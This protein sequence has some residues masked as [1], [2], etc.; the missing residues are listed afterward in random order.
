MENK[1]N[2]QYQF[3]TLT[4]VKDPVSRLLLKP[5]LKPLL[6]SATG[7]P[8]TTHRAGVFLRF[9][10]CLLL[11]V[12][13]AEVSGQDKLF[14]SAL[15][16]GKNTIFSINADGTNKIQL[17]N[18]V[19]NR[20]YPVISKDGI[21]MLYI[22]YKGSAG[23]SAWICRATVQG[24]NEQ[25]LKLIPDVGV[26]TTS[27]NI[28]AGLSWSNDKNKVLYSIY[29]DGF[30]SA[31]R[32]GD[33]Y[34]LNLSTNIVTNLTNE[35]DY[36]K[37][38]GLQYSPDNSKIIFQR[39][40]TTY[41]AF[42]WAIYVM[43][44]DGSGRV[45]LNFGTNSSYIFA[46]TAYSNSGSKV[47]YQG[48]N[49]LSDPI[50]LYIA[51]SD[52]TGAAQVIPS[53]GATT[54]IQNACFSPDDSKIA[55]MRNDSLI[56][57]QINGTV[58]SRFPKGTHNTFN[59]ITWANI[60][61]IPNPPSLLTATP[62]SAT[63][64]GLAWTD[65]STNETAFK[66]QRS[67]TSGTGFTTIATLAA[68][69]ITY[70]DNTVAAGTTY[71]YRILATNGA[72]DSAPSNEANATTFVIEK[73]FFAAIPTSE[74]NYTIY[75]SNV[76]GTGIQRIFNDGFNRNNYDVSNDGT[77]L[78]YIKSGGGLP[79]QQLCKSDIYGCN[80]QILWTNTDPI[81]LVYSLDWSNNKQK[82]VMELGEVVN[83]NSDLY[84]FNLLTS[85]LSQ[86]TNSYDFFKGLSTRSVRYSPDDSKILYQYCPT[87]FFALPVDM[88]V[89][90]ADGSNQIQLTNNG[91]QSVNSVYTPD[92]QKIIYSTNSF[93][94]LP[95]RIMNADG[96]NDQP[97]N[98]SSGANYGYNLAISPDGLKI[99]MDR[100][101]GIGDGN[102]VVTQINGTVLYEVPKVGFNGY[103]QISWV[104]TYYTLAPSALVATL[105]SSSQI[106]LTWTDNS[107]NED[108][109]VVE[110]SLTSGSG[111][112]ALA[113]LPANT[114]AYS[115]N[116]VSEGVSYFYRVT[117]LKA[118]YQ[119]PYSNEAT[120]TTPFNAPTVSAIAAPT[121]LAASLTFADNSTIE[122]NV[123][124]ER[125][126]TTGT[127]F[128]VLATL[129]ANTTTY[130]DNT[131]TEGITYFY[132]LRN[133]KT[134]STYSAY[135][136]EASV[137]VPAFA[138]PTA[139][140]AAAVNITQINLSWADNTTFETAYLLER[141]I[142]P[143]GGGFA[144]I[145]TLPA[146]STFYADNTVLPA[147]QYYYRVRGELTPIFS[148]Y[149]GVAGATTA[150]I[151]PLAQATNITLTAIFSQSLGI[152]WTNGGGTNRIVKINTSNNFTNLVNA[153]AYTAN[154]NYG[155]I[156]EQV[157]YNGGGN[158]AF[159]G[160]LQPKTKYFFKVYEYNG[161]GVTASYLNTSAQGNPA[162]FLTFATPSAPPTDLVF[163]D[164]T[165]T[166]ISGRF[167]PT[168]ADGYL[169]VRRA[170]G[171]TPQVPP[172][173]LTLKIGDI[174]FGEQ[175]VVGAGKLTT[176]K[177]EKL[178]PATDYTFDVYA[179]N[180]ENET[181]AYSAKPLSGTA[182]THNPL[183]ILEAIAPTEALAGQGLVTLSAFGKDFINGATVLWEGISLPAVFVSENELKAE[184]GGTYFLT[185]RKYNISVS[186][187]PLGGGKSKELPFDVKPSYL[188]ESVKVGDKFVLPETQNHLLHRICIYAFGENNALKQIKFD[189]SGTFKPQ[190][191][192]KN[193]FTLWA[194]K[195][196]LLDD[197]DVK[198]KDFPAASRLVFETTANTPL[199][200]K[201]GEP[202]CLLLTANIAEKATAGHTIQVS[203]ITE[204]DISLSK[205]VALLSGTIPYQI[206]GIQTI[207]RIYLN[208]PTDSLLLV[209]WC[210]VMK[211]EE[212]E[213]KWDFSQPVG[214]WHGI[215]LD[216]N[217][218]V[219]GI[220]LINNNLQGDLSDEI[221][222]DKENAITS[223]MRYFNCSG[224]KITGEMPEKIS[225]C[226]KME[227][228]DVSKNLM[229]GKLTEGIGEVR[230]LVTLWLSYNRFEE[231]P[232]SIENCQK[233]RN[234][235]CNNNKIS[236]LPENIGKLT[237]LEVA[238]FEVNEL[239]KLPSTFASLPNLK[240]C[241]LQNNALHFEHL[242]PLADRPS[243][244][245]T[246]VYAPQAKIGETKEIYAEEGKTFEIQIDTKGKSNQYTWHK[247]EKPYQTTKEPA[248]KEV[249]NYSKTGTYK[250]M[251]K[252]EKC[253]DL[254]L[255]SY[256]YKVKMY[257]NNNLVQ[258]KAVVENNDVF[259]ADES[260]EAV[261]RA[262]L[263]ANVENKEKAT[264][265]W[266]KNSTPIFQAENQKFVAQEVG[267]YSVRVLLPNGCTYLSETVSISKAEKVA[268]RLQ[269]EG[270]ILK[271]ITSQE[272]TNYEWFLNN[273]LLERNIT[274]SL[275][276]VESGRYKVRLTDKN[277]CQTTSAEENINVTALEEIEIE[278]LSIELFPNPSSDIFR[279]KMSKAILKSIWVFDAL[280]RDAHKESFT[281]PIQEYAFSLENKA[282]G[283][284][285][286][287]IQTTEGEAQIR[288]VKE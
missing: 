126:L 252:N 235:H 154:S 281:S 111:F 22:K 63:S 194:S 233:L 161:T 123:I 187:P 193:A 11:M 131:V 259:C 3:Q 14:Y 110:R 169:I 269:R 175:V 282:V 180:G 52:G 195:D 18:D 224:N 73:L 36:L 6:G 168:V 228:L 184:I 139:L 59:Q 234:L 105:I 200:I 30:P 51:N 262:Q 50:K 207:Q 27:G 283:I 203:P 209:R 124:L 107:S 248:Y 242:E 216:Q 208:N 72:G 174:L 54:G 115:D 250:L 238:R 189:L 256:E 133:L 89:M 137:G 279:V 237:S 231:I 77:E 45:K 15:I 55:F 205:E 9:A 275:N 32:D 132:R 183:P 225:K 41:F 147:T 186:N 44:A 196:T 38:N 8:P 99:A 162:S 155:G 267:N 39:L 249:V 202:L 215:D 185:A 150:D 117:A 156:G 239:K 287:R 116:T 230:N 270:N 245:K 214:K 83:R 190:D 79:Q 37:Q 119:S 92:S 221:F 57:A 274:S 219:R 171:S 198:L 67:L 125:S 170:K 135:S 84:V 263:P 199:P 96:T 121:P 108:S 61:T 153:T 71:Y 272:I 268:V 25:Q 94:R 159:V 26:N 148:A 33:I 98:L 273:K 12:G 144:L 191:L 78:I 142:L 81:N 182:R 87:G 75:V 130:T 201:V 204:K 13:A 69:T 120:A 10:L 241:Y 90:N 149:S 80:E 167:K 164:I 65:N 286:V 229:R 122:D 276:M 212:W 106:N 141:S 236:K 102:L 143:T 47:I 101:V 20:V 2:P 104:N 288:I 134:P 278:N 66:V 244:L 165:T 85:T 246:F 118:C 188:V 253:K 17:F 31:N 109:Y 206:G 166:T 173:G 158:T 258:I 29:Y 243:K 42:P 88:Y 64:I 28:F 86:L 113:T 34:E 266:L 48:Y 254:T 19:Y 43:N 146:G 160:G 136:A 138:A 49:S 210:R 257:C 24:L 60:V 218:K 197:K 226:K 163:T 211:G 247:D 271:A 127:G 179:Y 93:S 220:I 151:T 265:Q 23:D 157:V 181:I 140:F 128:T 35:W 103:S 82:V 176:F 222:T 7:S 46:S 74:T 232:E 68:N 260:I 40:E 172:N 1:L 251:V 177:A 217:G 192:E 100:G 255:E 76:D 114:V 227:Y 280:G 223:E 62:T 145:A 261:L 277:G 112:A 178:T 58:L 95:I 70:T 91:V 240:E 21:E 264:F 97:L 5:R 285:W 152:S 129:A 56:I 284:Y 16:G 53:V 213:R 4:V